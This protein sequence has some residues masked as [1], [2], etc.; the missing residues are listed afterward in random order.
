MSNSYSSS[1]RHQGEEG[2]F[3]Q[4]HTE[5]AIAGNIDKQDG[6]QLALTC[7]ATAVGEDFVGQMGGEV[8]LEL[9]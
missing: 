9:V 1:I 6:D 8:A 5:A 2:L 7:Q 4:F 3:A